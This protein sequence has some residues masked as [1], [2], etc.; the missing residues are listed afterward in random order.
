ME[1]S[2]YAKSGFGE[3]ERTYRQAAARLKEHLEKVRLRL[4]I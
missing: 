1:V 3:T 4:L 2:K